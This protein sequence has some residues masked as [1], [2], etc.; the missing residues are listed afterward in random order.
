MVSETIVQL[1]STL[2]TRVSLIAKRLAVYFPII[3]RD[4]IMIF[5]NGLSFSSQNHLADM[6]HLKDGRNHSRV[7]L[8]KESYYEMLLFWANKVSVKIELKEILLLFPSAQKT[9]HVLH[10]L[11]RWCLQLRIGNLLFYFPSKYCNK[12]LLVQCNI[13]ASAVQSIP[14]MISINASFFPPISA[15]ALR[16]KN[17]LIQLA[18]KR[19]QRGPFRPLLY[20]AISSNT[21]DHSHTLDPA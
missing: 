4:F 8:W 15:S 6:L 13:G 20:R 10:F 5:L 16:K 2:F 7:Y 9:A 1:A 21:M 3:S 17:I 14:K 18:I 19:A 11:A 12:F